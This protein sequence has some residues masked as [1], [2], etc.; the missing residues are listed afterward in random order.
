MWNSKAIGCPFLEIPD[1]CAREV[2]NFEATHY[3][4]LLL[5]TCRF[6]FCFS[7][8]IAF[9]LSFLSTGAASHDFSN[10]LI[11]FDEQERYFTG[12]SLS[13]PATPLLVSVFSAVFLI[14]Q[15]ALKS[16]AHR[17]RRP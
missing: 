7:L 6:S 5:L 12:V 8:C 11:I 4:Y 13:S 1:R 15:V 3:N 2:W 14:G 16:R 17:H 10:S 9:S